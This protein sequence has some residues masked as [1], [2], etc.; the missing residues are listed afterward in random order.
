MTPSM[1]HIKSHKPDKMVKNTDIAAK[2]RKGISGAR[3]PR[4]L[5]RRAADSLQIRQIDQQKSERQLMPSFWRQFMA[6]LTV[7]S[8]KKARYF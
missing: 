8:I 7:T 3:K 1:C 4:A 6:T 2:Q 5:N